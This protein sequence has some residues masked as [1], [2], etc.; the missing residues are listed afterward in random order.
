[1]MPM[2]AYQKYSC[3]ISDRPY[4]APLNQKKGEE[5]IM[6]IQDDCNNGLLD[7]DG[8]NKDYE[9]HKTL[10]AYDGDKNDNKDNGSGDDDVYRDGHSKDEWHGKGGNDW[11]QGGQRSKQQSL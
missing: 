4:L 11:G 7:Y 5:C 3:G 6:V 1:M 9:D 2:G 10:K 8:Q